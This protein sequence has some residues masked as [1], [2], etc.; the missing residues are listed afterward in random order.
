MN[1]TIHKY[2]KAKDIDISTI[3]PNTD[4]DIELPYYKCVCHV[5]KY[6]PPFYTYFEETSKYL[7]VTYIN[8]VV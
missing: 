8:Y 4:P 3:F 5:Y 2:Q 6:L 7:I 1:R